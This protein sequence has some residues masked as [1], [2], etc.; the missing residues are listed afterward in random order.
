MKPE[1]HVAADSTKLSRQE[2]E[3]IFKV[4]RQQSQSDEE[5]GTNE[6]VDWRLLVYIAIVGALLVLLVLQVA[7]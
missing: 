6:D 1:Q 3:A 5:I 4:A 7:G 2:L